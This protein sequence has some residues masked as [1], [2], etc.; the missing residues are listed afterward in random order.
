MATAALF[1]RFP[2]VPKDKNKYR[3][4]LEMAKTCAH[5]A[6]V[7]RDPAVAAEL[8]RMAAEYLQRAAGRKMQ[9]SHVYL[10]FRP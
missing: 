10:L 2:H 4:L 1:R 3:K 6:Q 8:R 5:Q 7:T 9:L